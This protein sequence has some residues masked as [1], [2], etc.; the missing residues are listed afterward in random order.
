MQQVIRTNL[1]LLTSISA[2]LVLAET[3]G[4][5][6]KQS[7]QLA[8]Q[9]SEQLDPSQ[10]AERSELLDTFRDTAQSPRL[11]GAALRRLA[12]TPS[13]D[14]QLHDDLIALLES[15]QIDHFLGA[16]TIQ[17]L[18]PIG[19]P[20]SRAVP[21]LCRV[22]EGKPS[23]GIFKCTTPL[24]SY[25]A[26]Q[27]AEYGD[28]AKVAISRLLELDEKYAVGMID[29]WGFPLYATGE[30]SVLPL[31]GV[32]ADAPDVE[33]RRT[34]ARN[35]MRLKHTAQPAAP[36]LRNALSD[37][38]EEVRMSSAAALI[39]QGER[40][41][42]VEVLLAA[43]HSS[44]AANRARLADWLPD[45][46]PRLEATDEVLRTLLLD[47]IAKVRWEAAKS[48]DSTEVYLTMLEDPETATRTRAATSLLKEQ[49]YVEQAFAALLDIARSTEGMN[50]LYA[51]GAMRRVPAE[52]RA[53]ANPLFAK[54]LRK[55]SP[56][57]DSNTASLAARYL[58]EV[59][60]PS[61]ELRAGVEEAAGQT[62]RSNLSAA[63]VLAAW[64]AL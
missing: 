9:H 51:V 38:D 24:Y 30:A 21:V 3:P 52:I 41:E 64:D 47:D 45:F 34:A 2:T 53:P 23:T 42:A 56:S 14:P 20:A 7:L 28:E 22:L 61:P 62:E 40:Q 58:R 48:L 49:A 36:A 1:A 46:D 57:Y 54:L 13:D 16:V 8:I 43:R 29:P 35:L 5:D 27:L 17:S 4:G 60:N 18:H 37:P 26:L 55:D 44:D 12:S 11:R 50:R 19:V 25:A 15:D 10:P 32:L 59:K 33:H 63:R 31:A 6:S 39:H